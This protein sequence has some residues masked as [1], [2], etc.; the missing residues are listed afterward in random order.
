MPDCTRFLHRLLLPLFVGFLFCATELKAQSP[1]LDWALSTGAALSDKGHAVVIDDLGFAY[2]AGYHQQTVDLDPGT[3]VL[4]AVG[5]GIFLQK[6]DG[7]GNLIWAVNYASTGSYEIYDLAL[8][9]S[10]NL[11]VVG[12][13][14]GTIDF[15]PGAGFAN[16]TAQGGKDMF[17]LKLTSGGNFLFVQPI[18]SGA[19][20]NEIPQAMELDAQ[21]NIVVTGWFDGSVD[22]DPG[23]GTTLLNS[24]GNGDIF[25]AKYDGNGNLLWAKALG[26]ASNDSGW[27]LT[28][29]AQSNVTVA[30]RFGS[31]VD[32]D[33]GVGTANLIAL[34]TFDG[35]LLR[36]DASGNLIWAKQLATA[37]NFSCTVM[38]IDT[39][40]SGN[41]L[42]GGIFFGSV[43]LDP[44]PNSVAASTNGTYDMFL[45]K[46]DP[47]GNF[48]W[49]HGIGGNTTDGLY[50]L[51][52]DLEG[53]VYAGGTFVGTVDFDPGIGVTQE[54]AISYTDIAV[55]KFDANGAFEWVAVAG[56]TNNDFIEQLRVSPQNQLYVTGSYTWTADFAPGPA[57]YNLTSVAGADAYVYR[58]SFCQQTDTTTLTA[59]TCDNYTL[60]AV[61]YDSSGSYFQQFQA[62]N[63]CDSVVTLHLTVNP[64]V[65]NVQTN[66]GGLEAFPAGA[67]YQWLAC[68]SGN[69]TIAGANYQTL[70]PTNPGNYAVVVTLG[71]CMDTSN[72][73]F[74]NPV[75]LQATV[76]NRIRLQPNPAADQVRVL[77]EERINR[78]FIMD[79]VGRVLW[80]Q[81]GGGAKALL[82]DVSAWPRGIYFVGIE[83]E[84]YMDYLRMVLE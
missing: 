56:G 28:V 15:D 1:V 76:E 44:G 25:I 8:D 30:G 2:C 78:L 40:T 37:A 47:A 84:G 60:N 61:T 39:D 62:S 46:T 77:S 43:D 38:D 10:N 21:G 53:N 29:D 48:L 18:N 5:T 42:L 70:F 27:A 17:L 45:M 68:D 67:Q 20:S 11:L 23:I 81:A 41:L 33:P 6:F 71:N 59:T 74:L 65:A 49:G 32:F 26:S 31:T 55:M 22:A 19:G 4:T 35:F 3:A 80:M 64:L 13:F 50:A 58:L 79:A 63:G 16:L 82:L 66:Q 36:L 83:A 9:S 34:G 72:C 57:V 52:T 54:T 24:V 69:A 14:T 7:Q 75:G 12:T 73:V 51:S